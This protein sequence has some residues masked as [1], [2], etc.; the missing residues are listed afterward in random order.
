MKILAIYLSLIIFVSI[1]IYSEINL[2]VI[3]GDTLNFGKSL[4]LK[5]HLEGELILKNLGNEKI[6]IID[7]VAS[8]G[9]TKSYLSKNEILP[10]DTAKLRISL[11]FPDKDGEVI[12]HITLCLNDTSNKKIIFVKAEIYSILKVLPF[13]T[14]VFNGMDINKEAISSAIKLQNNSPNDIIIKSVKYSSPD[15]RSDFKEN[16]VIKSKD[17]IFVYAYAKTHNYGR[18]DGA[19]SVAT[20]TPNADLEFKVL[21]NAPKK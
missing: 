1:N 7:L 9:C 16:M 8:C 17:T 18:F 6:K 3:G 5:Q 12:K 15:I 21:G 13:N 10:N 11:N 20:D 2:E 19:I 4:D 14:F